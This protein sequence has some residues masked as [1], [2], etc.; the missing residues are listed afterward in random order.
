MAYEE[1]M[2]E[3]KDK[4]QNFMA[5]DYRPYYPIPDYLIVWNEDLEIAVAYKDGKFELIPNH[6]KY[7]SD[8]FNDLIEKEK[9]FYGR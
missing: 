8:E 9:V 6:A 1:I 7:L 5:T 2:S 3:F 4:F